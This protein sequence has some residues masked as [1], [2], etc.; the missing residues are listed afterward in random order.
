MRGQQQEWKEK[1]D[2]CTYGELFSQAQA[3]IYLRLYC[4]WRCPLIRSSPVLCMGLTLN[5]SQFFPF[6]SGFLRQVHF[7]AFALFLDYFDLNL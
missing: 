6:E 3:P 7:Q 1:K 4:I 5:L 2:M